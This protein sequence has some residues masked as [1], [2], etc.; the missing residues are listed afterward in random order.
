MAVFG[1]PLARADDAERAVRA[2]LSILEGIE[3]LNVRHT[4]LDLQVRAAVGTGE[5]VIAVDPAPGDPLATGDIVNTAA[6]LQ[7]AA[8]PGAL[9]V[10]EGTYQLAH[11]AFR[12]VELPA[13]DAKG[14]ATPVAAWSVVEAIE[15]PGS[16]P[17]SATPLVGRDRE[18][19]L[20]ASVWGR[21]VEER[22]PHIVDV[23]APAGVGKTRLAREVSER[24][25]ELGGRA[26][27]G[28]S[29]P[30]EEQTPYRAAGQIVR[31]VAGIFENDE[32]GVA[33]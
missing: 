25:E 24:V 6:R 28:R 5:A 16:R 29:L 15:A 4:G 18:L 31:R 26:L 21:A 11:R 13:V 19:E 9:V 14:K 3:L 33:R 7:S 17:T 27:W 30:Y 22:R 23:V 32:V 8:A 2:G 10:D 20:I 12:L 1:A